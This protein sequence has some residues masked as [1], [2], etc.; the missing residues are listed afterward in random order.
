MLGTLSQ[1]LYQTS[2]PASNGVYSWT[3]PNTPSEQCRVRI[4]DVNLEVYDDSDGNF[5]IQSV[6]IPELNLTTPNGGE[7][8]Q[9]GTSQEI[10]WTS[11][12]L[13]NVKIEYSSHDGTTLDGLAVME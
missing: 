3:V 1:R 7:S 5:T 10:I 12:D 9:A 4:T 2:M 6:V 8:W 11:Q 13:E